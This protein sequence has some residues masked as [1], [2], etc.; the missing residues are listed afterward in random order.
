MTQDEQR[1]LLEAERNLRKALS[2]VRSA[3]ANG[4]RKGVHTPGGYVEHGL[5]LVRCA[6]NWEDNRHDETH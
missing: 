5:T 6:L 1:I 4:S 3:H 2:L